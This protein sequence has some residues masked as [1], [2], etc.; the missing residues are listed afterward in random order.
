MG[1]V[2]IDFE[3]GGGKS[4]GVGTFFQGSDPGGVVV[5]GREV[6]TNPQDGAGPE[7]F[8]T[9]GR[10]TAHLEAAKEAGGW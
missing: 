3:P 5:Q 6:G 8:S 9:Q 2:V 10:A 1:E 4:I 7:Y